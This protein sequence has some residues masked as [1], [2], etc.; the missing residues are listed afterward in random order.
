L[1]DF[2]KILRDEKPDVYLGYTVKPNVFGS[3]A[4]HIHGIR[5]INNIAGLGTV[6]GNKS[7]ITAIVRQLYR[8]ALSRSE[9]VFFQ[10]C[11]DKSYFI[12]EG[13]IKENISDLLPGSGV[14]LQKFYPRARDL[15]LPEST[16]RVSVKFLMSARLLWDKGV[17]EFVEAARSL[18][19]KYRNVEFNLMGF[20]DESNP[21]S[22]AASDIQ[23][24]VEEGVILYLGVAS[25][26]RPALH[27]A[28]C[29][30][31]PS[32][33]RE[34][35]PRSLLEAAAMAKPIITTDSVGCRQVVDDEVNGFL[36]KARDATDLAS[37][38]ERF[39]QLTP[40]ERELMGISGRQ[41]AVNRFDEKLV[42]MKYL[43][44]IKLK[45]CHRP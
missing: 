6:F 5:V 23:R 24:W 15:L 22:V 37:K 1:F 36:C 21:Q 10:N 2:Y 8:F 45:T 31:L 14:D 39:L 26:V 29:V 20:I 18:K 17:G 40:K 9:K 4:A 43:E 32:Y 7:W 27:D 42:I 12:K 41:I 11:D 44:L 3:L 35:V 13:L 30:V 34:G 16:K 28:D 19:V 25:D 38:M 33:Y